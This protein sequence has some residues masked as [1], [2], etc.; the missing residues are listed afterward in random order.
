M[1]QLAAVCGRQR[2]VR[3]RDEA[4][5]AVADAHVAELPG[6]VDAL[7]WPRPTSRL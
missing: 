6:V 5:A 2:T 7:A 3:G 1:P 4:E